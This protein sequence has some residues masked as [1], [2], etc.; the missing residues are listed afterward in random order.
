MEANLQPSRFLRINSYLSAVDDSEIDGGSSWAGRLWAGWRDDFWNVSAGAKHVGDSFVPRVGFVRRR[1]VRTGY[2]T[3]G[4]H[5]QPATAAVN[6]I[7]PYVEVDWVGDLDGRMLT[8]IQSA[9]LSVSFRDGSR[10]GVD[11]SDNFERL[12]APFAVQGDAVVPVG[13][14]SFREVAFSAGTSA[15]RALSGGA[16]VATGGFY[17]GDRTS[18]S[19]NGQWRLSYK[20]AVDASAQRNR[21]DIP[22]AEPFDADVYGGRVTFAASTTLFT[23]AFLQYNAF[24]D[25]LVTNLRLNVIHAPLSDLFLVYTERRN[26]E[27]IRPTERFLSLKVTKALAF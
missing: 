10:L 2:A 11:A 16:R 4:V 26:R 6:E 5:H 24:T 27:G 12:D 25:D 22:G 18:Y 9:S 17:N 8:R 15:G 7:N 13:D 1:G 23:S 3:A 20:L 21:I 19:V 14:H